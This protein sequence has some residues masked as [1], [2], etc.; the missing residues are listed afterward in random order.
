M[1]VARELLL[2]LDGAQ[3]PLLVTAEVQT[4]GR[5]RLGRRWEAPPG[6][7]LL[8]SLALQP[9][10]LAP[11]QGAALVWMTATA[12]CE[13]VE[14]VA[15]VPSTLK[16]PND[17]LLPVGG[18]HAKAAGILLEVSLGASEIEWA[19]LGC[20]INVSAAPPPE[21]TRYPATSLEAAAGRPVSRLELLRALLRRLDGWHARLMA[22]DRAMLHAAWSRRLT[23]I[24]EPVR[25]ETTAGPIEG[26]AE[27]VDEGGALLVRD[28]AG[29]LHTIT[30]GDVGLAP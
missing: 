5:G 27:G 30:T 21:A 7:A 17:L 3:L 15:A 6:T 16:W 9:T 24:G 28:S 14:E 19:I 26:R 12:L 20:G 4:A 2:T 13:A 25:V 18:G 11:E 8:L 10:W 23:G 29:Q 1:D 22:G